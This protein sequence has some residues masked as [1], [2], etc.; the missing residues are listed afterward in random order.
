M[1]KNSRLDRQIRDSLNTNQQA[2]LN[3]NRRLAEMYNQKVTDTSM[4]EDAEVNVFTVESYR[5]PSVIRRIGA[6]AAAAAVVAGIGGSIFALNGFGNVPEMATQLTDVSES[7]EQSEEVPEETTEEMP[8]EAP[9]EPEFVDNNSYDMSTKE[10][11]YAKMINSF[12]NYDQISGKIVTNE[13]YKEQVCAV[14]D[15]SFDLTTGKAH[16]YLSRVNYENSFEDII[17]GAAPIGEEDNWISKGAF[18]GHLNLYCDGQYQYWLFGDMTYNQAAE[19]EMH[20]RYGN[21]IQIDK[22]KESDEIWQTAVEG[23]GLISEDY[24]SPYAKT[25]TGINSH[26][27]SECAH[28]LESP[29][30]LHVYDFDTWE[31]VGDIEYIG[32]DCVEISMDYNENTVHTKA[33]IDKETGCALYALETTYGEITDYLVTLEI[34]FDEDAEPVPEIDL[35]EY[36][37]P[38]PISDEEYYAYKEN[39]HGETYG[40]A[41]E[42]IC[43]DNADLLPDLISFGSGYIRTSEL[44]E[45]SNCESRQNDL[46]QEENKLDTDVLICSLNIYNCE[47]E[48]I[49]VCNY[50]GSPEQKAEFD[51]TA[52]NPCEHCGGNAEAESEE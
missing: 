50:Y 17:N 7:S 52:M 19:A 9:T 11:I 38:E 31:I 27:G 22:M 33:Y 13:T 1:K 20:P 44:F 39:S 24:E 12:F 16:S 8:T 32:R 43:T 35:S 25:N 3:I 5:K 28:P 36:T 42:H 41:P 4:D 51:A 34:N 6:M 14:T 46:R 10:G 47:G 18:F 15:F 26:L 40:C 37:M 45:I 2:D 21:P 48:Y 49:D 23:D 30:F 29:M